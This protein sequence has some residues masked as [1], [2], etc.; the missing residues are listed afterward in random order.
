MEHDYDAAAITLSVC[1]RARTA[2][3][4]ETKAPVLKNAA[5]K[6]QPNILLPLT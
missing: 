5:T 2:P 4:D 6:I 3:L 1:R